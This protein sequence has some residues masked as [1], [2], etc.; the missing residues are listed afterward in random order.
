MQKII[1]PSYTHIM[2][3]SAYGLRPPY[4]TFTN[5]KPIVFHSSPP[6]PNTGEYIYE[7]PFHPPIGFMPQPQQSSGPIHTIPAPNLSPIGP[8]APIAPIHSNHIYEAPTP[9]MRPY[10]PPVRPVSVSKV[11]LAER[12]RPN[13]PCIANTNHKAD[14]NKKLIPIPTFEH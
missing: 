9:T 2:K 5:L 13:P 8:L 14:L 3:P 10:Y 11:T 4:P 1:L 12:I 6:G 7:N